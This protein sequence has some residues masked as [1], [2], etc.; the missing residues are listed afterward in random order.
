MIM[1]KF[2]LHVGDVQFLI[3]CIFITPLCPGLIRFHSQVLKKREGQGVSS[4]KSGTCDMIIIPTHRSY[5]PLY[6][7]II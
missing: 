7:M 3:V 2:A 4:V 5:K 1:W 6:S